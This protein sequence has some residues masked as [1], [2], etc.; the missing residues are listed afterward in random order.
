MTKITDEEILDTL[1]KEPV[2]LLVLA[3]KLGVL[4]EGTLARKLGKLA[5]DGRVKREKRSVSRGRPI[6]IYSV[7]SK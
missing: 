4:W 1:K 5:E 2:T 6:Y 3:K 7:V